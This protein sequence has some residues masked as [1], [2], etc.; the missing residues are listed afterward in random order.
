MR[1]AF[2]YTERSKILYQGT[3]SVKGGRFEFTFPVPLD[4][5]YSD[6]PGLLNLYA[7]DEARR[8]AV[9]LSDASR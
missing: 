7:L 1:G 8:E 9:A 5:N 3:D 6:E 2:T 4:I